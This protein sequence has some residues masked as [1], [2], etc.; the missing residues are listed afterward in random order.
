[1]N[2]KFGNFELKDIWIPTRKLN[3]SDSPFIVKYIHVL[4]FVTKDSGRLINRGIFKGR[5]IYI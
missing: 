3:K 2:Y 4:L 1:M 5:L